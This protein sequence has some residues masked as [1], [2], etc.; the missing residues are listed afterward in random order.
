MYIY[1]YMHL[2]TINDKKEAMN[3]KRTRRVMWEGLKRERCNYTVIQ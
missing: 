3:L 2:T 1:T